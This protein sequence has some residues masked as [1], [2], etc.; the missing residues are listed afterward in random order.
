MFWNA[1]VSVGWVMAHIA[2][3][4]VS[5]LIKP[6]LHGV[7][8]SCHELRRRRKQKSHFAQDHGAYRTIWLN[9]VAHIPEKR[10]ERVTSRIS[11]KKE[12]NEWYHTR[13]YG[14]A[15]FVGSLKIKVSFAEY[16]LFYR[17]FFASETY[18]VTAP[19]NCSHPIWYKVTRDITY[20][21]LRM[22]YEWIV[23]R[24]CNMNELVRKRIKESAR[25]IILRTQYEWSVSRV[26][27]KN[28]MNDSCHTSSWVLSYN[29]SRD[30][31]VS[32]HAY[33]RRKKCLSRITQGHETCHRLWLNCVTRTWEPRNEWVMSHEFMS[34]IITNV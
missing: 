6:F 34:R 31:T 3:I 2:V 14:V 20:A 9:Y 16:R 7:N 11:Q 8:E 5:Y 33:P 22:Q 27:D 29:V 32:C 26:P 25:T 23:S 21:I 19:T 24:V 17:V 4:Y 13:S 15:T 18:N 30:V 12:I 1:C 28:A 10:N